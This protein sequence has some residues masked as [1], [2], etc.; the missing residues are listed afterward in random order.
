MPGVRSGHDRDGQPGWPLFDLRI[1]TPDLEIRP[2][3]EADLAEVAHA[4][5]DDLEI[6]PAAPRFEGLSRRSNSSA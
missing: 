3:T 4:I 5:P 2:M 6:D 1:A